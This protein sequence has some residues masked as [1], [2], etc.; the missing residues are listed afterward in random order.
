[1]TIREL[2]CAGRPTIR[3]NNCPAWPACCPVSFYKTV[4]LF[5]TEWS[6][7]Y[8]GHAG[9]LIRPICT[10]M[11]VADPGNGSIRERHRPLLALTF[12]ERHMGKTLAALP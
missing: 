3:L 5:L 10:A 7:Y 11:M 1:M 8:A 12:G 4:S 9:Q 6:R 2:A